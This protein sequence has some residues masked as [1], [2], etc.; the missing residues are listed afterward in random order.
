M[1]IQ[2]IK[3][4]SGIQKKGTKLNRTKQKRTKQK[5]IKQNK[6]KIKQ[7]ARQKKIIITVEIQSGQ[8]KQETTKT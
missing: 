1:V 6:I 8:G 4:K 3:K 2:N 7:K 5:R